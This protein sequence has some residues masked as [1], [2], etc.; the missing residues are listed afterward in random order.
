MDET[1]AAD[2]LRADAVSVRY[3]DVHAL[4]EASFAVGAGQFLA[5]T[6]PSGAG[7]TTLLWAL[8][9]ALRVTGGAVTWSGQPVHERTESARAGIV[10][11]PQGNGLARTLTAA[12]N[13]LVALVGTGAPVQGAQTRAAEALA[14][15][16]LEESGNHL[17][18]ELSGG[19]QQRVAI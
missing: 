11:V 10:L 1:A 16:G 14:L 19:Q 13:I 3:G 6:G 7:K 15:V 2:A 5:V 17:I 8:A 4:Q 18:E 12:E 9:G